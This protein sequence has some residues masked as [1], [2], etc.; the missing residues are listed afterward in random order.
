MSTAR[1]RVLEMVSE[2]FTRALTTISGWVRLS[3]TELEAIYL[4]LRDASPD[5][6]RRVERAHSV[7]ALLDY[8][9]MTGEPRIREAADWLARLPLSG[10]VSGDKA[11]AP[12]V[13]GVQRVPTEP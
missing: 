13:P 10:G 2:R 7:Q 8:A 9:T 11:G 4:E 6:A 3:Y 5:E 1:G 12:A